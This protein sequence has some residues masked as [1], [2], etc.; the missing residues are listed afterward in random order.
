ML[1][2]QL[3]RP[4]RAPGRN[5]RFKR[6]VFSVSVMPGLGPGTDGFAQCTT[7][8]ASADL[9]R[10]SRIRASDAVSGSICVLYA[11]PIQDRRRHLV[12]WFIGG[13]LLETTEPVRHEAIDRLTRQAIRS[14]HRDAGSS[15]ARGGLFAHVT[16]PG[17]QQTSPSIHAKLVAAGG[18][19]R[20]R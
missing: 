14:E 8:S 9:S 4:G 11:P 2:K 6:A 16:L 1:Q 7:A 10:S 15:Q 17:E 18:A 13:G 20:F 12:R 5:N 3:V 19:R